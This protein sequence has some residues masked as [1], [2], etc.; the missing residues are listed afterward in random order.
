M[1]KEIPVLLTEYVYKSCVI[2]T[3]VIV[4]LHNINQL[5]MGMFSMDI[6]TEF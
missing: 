1:L 6:G 4:F 3:T 5:V 2:M